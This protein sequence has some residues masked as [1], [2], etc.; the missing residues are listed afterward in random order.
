MTTRRGF[1]TS[2]A[3]AVV[4]AAVLPVAVPIT[5][6]AS[7]TPPSTNDTAGVDTQ[8]VNDEYRRYIAMV[9]AAQGPQ[10]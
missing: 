6:A 9:G 8:G 1:L 2:G 5:A 7:A 4:T 3:T 10:S